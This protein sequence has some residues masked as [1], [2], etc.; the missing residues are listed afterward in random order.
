MLAVTIAAILIMICVDA[1]AATVKLIWD[2]PQYRT[3][4]TPLAAS[5]IDKY[6]IDWKHLP[7]GKIG[8]KFP[9]GT[10]TGY[11]LYVPLIGRYEFRIRVYDT[12]GLVSDWDRAI[13]ADVI[14]DQTVV[15]LPTTTTINKCAPV[16]VLPVCPYICRPA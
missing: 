8:V 9:K 2:R 12:G 3:D 7:T 5:E 13:Q 6:E 14:N 11:G 16:P 4:C 15:A 1:D 10:L